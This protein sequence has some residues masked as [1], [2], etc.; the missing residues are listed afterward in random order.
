MVDWIKKIL[1]P[2]KKDNKESLEDIF[3]EEVSEDIDDENPTDD[4]NNEF[5]IDKTPKNSD[6]VKKKKRSKK[7]SKEE[8]SI[9][10]EP[11]KCE[12]CGDIFYNE[13]EEEKK[14][15]ICKE[16]D[17]YCFICGIRIDNNSKHSPFCSASHKQRFDFFKRNGESIPIYIDNKTTMFT[18]KYEFKKIK[19]AIKIYRKK[20]NTIR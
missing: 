10:L 13:S 8:K 20:L 11:K 4:I 18:K 17:R 5:I 16:I 7:K 12:D 19:K 2:K 3:L 6:I 15:N 14:C 1:S 9:E